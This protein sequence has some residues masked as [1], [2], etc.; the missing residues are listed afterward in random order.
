MPKPLNIYGGWIITP[1]STHPA[2]DGHAQV[3]AVVAAPSR[4]AA[5]RAFGAEGLRGITDGHLRD[6]FSTSESPRD[7]IALTEPGKVFLCT[8]NRGGPVPWYDVAGNEVPF[9]PAG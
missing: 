4:A 2:S 8:M 5:V 3:R 1:R 7:A 6:Y 9:T